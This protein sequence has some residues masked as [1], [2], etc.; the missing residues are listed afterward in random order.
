VATEKFTE[1]SLP[2][3]S[4]LSDCSKP[5]GETKTK[6]QNTHSTKTKTDI[7]TCD[8]NL[9]SSR[10]MDANVKAQSI[11]ARERWLLGPSNTTTAGPEYSSIAGAQEKDLKIPF[12]TM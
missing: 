9:L 7:S 3:Y 6:E 1:N 11:I 5:R 8:Y 2:D 10:C 12:M 4:Q